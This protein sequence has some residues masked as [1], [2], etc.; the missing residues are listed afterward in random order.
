M[1]LQRYVSKEL[2]HF[3]GSG[4]TEEEQ[5]STLVHDII[6]DGWLKTSSTFSTDAKPEETVEGGTLGYG[7]N[8]FAPIGEM[9]QPRVVSFCDIP[10]GDLETTCVNI[11]A[12]AYRFLNPF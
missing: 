9:Y 2:T 4:R 6:R 3:V 8:P 7:K 10:E 1:S 5:Y 11:A 12:S